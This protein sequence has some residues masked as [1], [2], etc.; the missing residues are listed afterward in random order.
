MEDEYTLTD[1]FNPF[2]FSADAADEIKKAALIEHS[3]KK[4]DK[5]LVV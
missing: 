2:N 4:R 5:S 1:Q 3:Q